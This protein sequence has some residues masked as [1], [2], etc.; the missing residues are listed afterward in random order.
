LILVIPALLLLTSSG[1][2][3]ID[4]VGIL[5]MLG[6]SALYALH[7]PIN[8]RVLY[9]MPAPTVTLYT[10]IAMSA[11][12]V[13]VYGFQI[14]FASGI[15]TASINPASILTSA[16]SSALVGLL[17]LTLVTFCSRLTLFLGVKHLGGLQTAIL[18]LGE[19]LVTLSF[20]HLW[21][22]E[23]FTITQWG[24]VFLLIA[25]LALAIMEKPPQGKL[26]TGGWFDW[27]RRKTVTG[28]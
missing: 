17:G 13:P 14:I 16:S 6:A 10:L 11:V 12:V 20:S 9:D 5:M 1:E 23:Q 25:S 3:T 4:R 2:H 18:G 28:D 26:G 27:L 19:L 24:G 7:L 15:P 22:Q 8:Q 21:L